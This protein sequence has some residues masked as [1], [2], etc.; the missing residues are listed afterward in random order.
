MTKRQQRALW[1][2]QQKGQARF[3][4]TYERKVYR[5]LSKQLRSVQNYIEAEGIKEASENLLSLIP[6]SDYEAV[7]EDLYSK[8]GGYF[9]EQT[10]ADIRKQ[11]KNTGIPFTSYLQSFIAAYSAERITAITQTTRDELK[12][13]LFSLIQEGYSIPN[14]AKEIRKRVRQNFRNRSKVIARTEIISAANYGNWSGAKAIQSE[15]R[16]PLRKV[17]LAT[18]DR[19]TRPSHQAANG[20][21]ELLDGKFNVGGELLRYPG[22]PAGSAR[23]VIQCR[24]TMFYEEI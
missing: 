5:L 13:V 21:R 4:S 24:C 3:V 18:P 11:F 23:N 22:D 10:K 1:R 12:L 16:M 20:Q 9:F 6:D 15:L 7:L 2:R 19:R 8:V 14:A 17:W